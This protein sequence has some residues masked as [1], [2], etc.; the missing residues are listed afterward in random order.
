MVVEH[1][2][3]SLDSSGARLRLHGGLNTEQN[4]VSVLAIQGGKEGVGLGIEIQ[5]SLK[6]ARH[7]GGPCRVICLSPAPVAPGALDFLDLGGLHLPEIDQ[8]QCLSRL[9]FD[10]MLFVVPDVNFCSQYCSL[11]LFFWPSI[12]PWHKATSTAFA[13]VTDEAPDY[14]FARRGHTPGKVP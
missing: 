2:N 13:Y 8:R 11:S 5:S 14:F 10:Q 12:H 4:G 6:V 9:I 3:E 7:C 1:P